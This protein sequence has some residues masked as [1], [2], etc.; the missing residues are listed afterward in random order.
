MNDCKNIGI[1]LEF[2]LFRFIEILK[3]LASIYRKSSLFIAYV[4]VVGNLLRIFIPGGTRPPG[5]LLKGS[6][7]FRENFKGSQ[8][9]KV[10]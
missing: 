1:Y 6:E 2:N 10:T 8:I 4:S 9:N 3:G 5:V 7:I